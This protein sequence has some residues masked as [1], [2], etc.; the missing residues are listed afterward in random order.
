MPFDNNN[1]KMRSLVIDDVR[2]RTTFTKKY[3]ERKPYEPDNPK[4]IKAFIPGT[5]VSV[6]TKRR[7]KVSKND[8]LLI[9]EAMKMK[10]V[11]TAPMD[12]VIKEVHVKTGQQV[13]KN[14]PLIT[15]K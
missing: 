4:V 10:N 14:T 8:E 1:T 12:G 3:A 7:H 9:L 2:Y 13:A 11:I 15:Y 5:I 6:M